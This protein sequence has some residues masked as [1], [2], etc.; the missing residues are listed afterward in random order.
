VLRENGCAVDRGV[1]DAEGLQLVRQGAPCANTDSPNAIGVVQAR[2]MHLV[3]DTARQCGEVRGYE[4]T[5]AVGLP[6]CSQPHAPA[7]P[8]LDH[9]SSSRR[10]YH[11][12]VV[13]SSQNM[14]SGMESLFV[15]STTVATVSGRSSEDT[16]RRPRPA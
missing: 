12:D 16:C 5:A 4:D 14:L 8:L 3:A 9:M 15:S 13:L 7:R 1:A 6:P 2:I 10:K 11:G